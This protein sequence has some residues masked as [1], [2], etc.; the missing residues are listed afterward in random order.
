M[1]MELEELRQKYAPCS[2]AA[3]A[4]KEGWQEAYAAALAHCM[5]GPGC[6]HGAECGVGRRLAPVT[7]LSGSVV[8][9]WDSL[10]RVLAKHEMELKWVMGGWVGGPEG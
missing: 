9:I 3:A 4:A 6:V 10:E 1:D 2:P 5:H 8:R 7:L